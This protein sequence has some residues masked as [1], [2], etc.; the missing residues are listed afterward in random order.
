[1]VVTL[2]PVLQNT[3][4]LNIEA[5]ATP[6]VQ[7]DSTFTLILKQGNGILAA[8]TL[9]INPE[10]I[11]YDVPPRVSTYQTLKDFYV[12]DHG[13]GIQAVTL[14]GTTGWKPRRIVGEAFPMDGFASF[15]HLYKEIYLAYQAERSYLEKQGLSAFHRIG[16]PDGLHV[17]ILDKMNE[18]TYT[19]VFNKFLLRRSRGR[20]LLFQYDIGLT[21]ITDQDTD[22]A[23]DP[24]QLS[25]LAGV[26]EVVSGKPQLLSKRLS[27]TQDVIAKFRT[28]EQDFLDRHPSFAK[29]LDDVDRL[30]QL[31]NDAVD[32]FDRL[33]GI[34]SDAV[35]LLSGRIN[36][37][38]NGL[39]RLSNVTFL[40][41]AFIG[42]LSAK[43]I[44]SLNRVIT[45]F[46][47][48]KCSLEGLT[49]GQFVPNVRL[50]DGFPNCAA[51]LGIESSQFSLSDNTFQELFGDGNVNLLDLADVSA[52]G[53]QILDDIENVD[54]VLEDA[55]D[56]G[57]DAAEYLATLEKEAIVDTET[58]LA[59]EIAKLDI[60]SD[61]YVRI[62]DLE[63]VKVNADQSLEEIAT[64]QLGD[65]GRWKEIAAYNNLRYP[66]ISSDPLEQ[67]GPPIKAL[68]LTGGIA[69][70]DL[71]I[72]V[73]AVDGIGTGYR[74]WIVEGAVTEEKFV[75]SVDENTLEV[76]VTTA[77]VGTFTA[78][79]SVT[80]Y[81]NPDHIIGVVLQ[82]G[83]EL[84]VPKAATTREDVGVLDKYTSDQDAET[85]LGTDIQLGPDGFIVINSTT[86]DVDTISGV[87]NVVQ[88]LDLRFHVTPGSLLH[89]VRYGNPA[90][91][92]IG[93]VLGEPFRLAV[94]SEMEDGLRSDARVH[95]ARVTKY[96]VEGDSAVVEM[97][98]AIF[99]QSRQVVA[100]FRFKGV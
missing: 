37:L 50:L 60:V 51:T 27:N 41:S 73:S 48:I 45:E 88:A 83:D 32:E 25:N 98:I 38:A 61:N 40:A 63:V 23:R 42:D 67:Y 89:H 20:P 69:P 26:G 31:A 39:H 71:K 29:V 95:R 68:T 13:L 36:G 33:T 15:K 85:L 94:I 10:S 12:D 47:A 14:S 90:I 43:T 75:E 70:T 65:P 59:S 81:N 11:A 58:S 93:Q 78:A 53:K 2:G 72:D 30:A 24:K 34:S 86:K 84:K 87:D 66:F 79:A 74:L 5:A 17:K 56:Y 96:D 3:I 77:F 91:P 100:V 21:V 62:E 92:F 19:A 46:G 44:G 16:K 35:G 57:F 52:T 76:F 6:K 18:L 54:F 97:E 7:K 80:L 64:A 8:H 28:D 82:P 99:M 4:P 55:S 1:M 49:F 9:R 22:P